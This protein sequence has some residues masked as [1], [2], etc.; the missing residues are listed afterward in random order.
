VNAK[1]IEELVW[2]DVQSFLEKPGE[3]LERV[4]EQ[5]AEGQEGDDLEERYASL[6]RR[7]AAKQEEKSHYV[8]VYA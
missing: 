2:R 6:T 4:R 7:L 5:L 8:K 1:W 3:V